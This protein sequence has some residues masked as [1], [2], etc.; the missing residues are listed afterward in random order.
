MKA[1]RI[2]PGSRR[3]ARFARPR[4]VLPALRPAR[5]RRL[6]SATAVRVAGELRGIRH[7]DHRR[8][9]RDRNARS[10][11]FG[12][13]RHPEPAPSS[14]ETAMYSPVGIDRK[15][16]RIPAG[17]DQSLEFRRALVDHG[18]GV[19]STASDEQRFAVGRHL[20]RRRRDSAHALAERLERNRPH[21]LV[22]LR[23]DDR[24]AVAIAVRHIQPLAR[25]VPRERC[26]MQPYGDGVRRLA[27]VMSTRVTE[28]VDAMPRASTTTLLLAASASGWHTA[29]SASADARRDC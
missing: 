26:R 9:I 14:E 13:S 6:F 17:R 10:A 22:A 5:R 16:V 19:D 18:D 23:V 25:F 20:K 24:N 29:H 21:D 15:P 28:P 11:C 12:A 3:A 1:R 4:G 2:A 8:P 27:E 7:R